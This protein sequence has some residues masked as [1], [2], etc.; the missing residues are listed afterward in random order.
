MYEQIQYHSI[1]LSVSLYLHCSV[2]LHH[3]LA[4]SLHLHH[5]LSHPLQLIG[6]LSVGPQQVLVVHQQAAHLKPSR[7]VS[8]Q[9][10]IKASPFKLSVF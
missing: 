8:G 6:Q 2:S 10:A 1:S 3:G 7:R 4:L 9:I 5:L